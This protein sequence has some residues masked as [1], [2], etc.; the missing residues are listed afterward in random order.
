MCVVAALRLRLRSC[1]VV[2]VSVFAGVS[3]AGERG[4]SMCIGTDAGSVDVFAIVCGLWWSVEHGRR[5]WLRWR[6]SC[7][8]DPREVLAGLTSALAYLR[9]VMQGSK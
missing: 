1:V 8:V 3:F 5:E 9:E 7:R 2:L 4:E 6:E